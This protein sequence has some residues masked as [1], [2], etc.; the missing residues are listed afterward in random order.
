MKKTGAWLLRNALEQLGVRHTFGIPGVHTTEI[1]DELNNSN[2]IR[3][4]LV[5]HEGGASFMADAVSRS[6][7]QIGVL[8]VVPA[9]GLTHAMSGIG[10]AFL[11]GIPMLVIS[12]G[13][14][15]DTPHKYQ[16]HQ[17]DLQALMA[18]L[19]KA[20]FKVESHAEVMPKIFEA[21]EIAKS[22]EPGPVYVE[23]PMNIQILKG[24]VSDLP[25]APVIKKCKTEL[26]QKAVSQAAQMLA[27]ARRPGIFLGWGAKE[28]RD[29]SIRIAEKLGAPVSTSLQ[30]LSSFPHDHAL[31][32]GMGFGGAAVPAAAEIFKDCDVILA[33]GV[34]FGEIA[35]G[36]YS[37]DVPP[38]LIH[39]DINPEALGANYPA[40]ISLEADAAV[41][42]KALDKALA[43]ALKET[44]TQE[45]TDISADISQK[46]Q[47]YMQEWLDHDSKDKVNPAVFF[48]ALDQQ[49][50]Q[51]AFVLTDD[52]NHTFLTA[53]LMPIRDQRRFISPTDFNCMGYCVPAAI[54]TKLENRNKQVVGIVGDGAFLM[55]AME[56]LSASTEGLGLV[57]FV[58]SDGELSQISQAQDVPYNR[59]P[60][61]I[62]PVL[63]YEPFARSVGAAYVYM[64]QNSDVE[65]AV[66]QALECAAK[67]QPVIVEVNIDYSKKTRFTKGAI[68][69]NLDR[70]DLATKIRFIGRAL[71]RKITG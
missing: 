31:H 26:D 27:K 45:K 17:M 53:E 50:S 65:K 13:I 5:T 71:M 36:S 46:K 67:G 37:M 1:Y 4:M 34:R 35:T 40:A 33:V 11:D 48:R 24:T 59:K 63:K 43:G 51:D 20:T 29:Y 18:P 56:I 39:I 32:T 55:T 16:L 44:T 2:Q 21:Y 30:G 6:S 62:L 64:G 47:A 58:F 23:V 9:A 25:A 10:E 54:A 28:A 15:T 52:G 38:N 42:M 68:K 12:G 57:Y 8:V 66:A 14:R 70:L 19:T 61:T 22:G 3:P 41:A 49:L 69:V 60:C 7:D